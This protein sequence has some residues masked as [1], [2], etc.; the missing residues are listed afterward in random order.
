MTQENK[1]ITI[2]RVR[3]VLVRGKFNVGGWGTSGKCGCV[4]HHGDIEVRSKWG[5][6]KEEVEVKFFTS[7]GESKLEEIFEY[8]CKELGDYEI[9][10]QS[11]GIIIKNGK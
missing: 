8:L 10:K 5:C 1:K 4:G 9:H 3:G 6:V 11:G 7:T 2:Q